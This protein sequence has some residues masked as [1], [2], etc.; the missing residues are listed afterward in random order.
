MGVCAHVH[1]THTCVSIGTLM[2]VRSMLHKCNPYVSGMAFQVMLLSY[3]CLL[4]CV[5]YIPRSMTHTENTHVHGTSQSIY[6]CVC[7]C[8]S[9]CIYI[10]IC[11][12]EVHM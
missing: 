5:E 6:M 12:N 2:I 1:F 9:L 11:E 10:Y 8:I 7:V 4:L 3:V